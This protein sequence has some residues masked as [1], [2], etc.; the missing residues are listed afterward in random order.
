MANPKIINKILRSRTLK[1]NESFRCDAHDSRC[2][3][4][5]MD[6]MMSRTWQKQNELCGGSSPAKAKRE[7]KED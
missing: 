3:C 5:R 6:A 1:M 7:E 2:Y 4:N